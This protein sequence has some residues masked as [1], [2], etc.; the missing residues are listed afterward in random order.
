MSLLWEHPVLIHGRLGRGTV[1]DDE[2]T[3]REDLVVYASARAR[4]NLRRREGAAP[5]EGRAAGHA[6]LGRLTMEYGEPPKLDLYRVDFS[7]LQ[8]LDHH[9][10]EGY[11]RTLPGG[12]RRHL[13]LAG[14]FKWKP[15]LRAATCVGSVFIAAG[16]H[17]DAIRRVCWRPPASCTSTAGRRCRPSSRGERDG[18]RRLLWP[19][20]TAAS[21]NPL[22]P[23]CLTMAAVD[24]A[25]LEQ[26]SS[27]LQ[28]YVYM[29]VDP[30]TGV[31]FYV[32]KG[33]GLRHTAH[34]SEALL[35]VGHLIRRTYVT[36]DRTSR[37][38]S[39]RS[40]RLRVSP[41]ASPP[42]HNLGL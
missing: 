23:G 7:E 28:A 14:N 24:Q 19:A 17:S 34:V 2:G 42:T 12:R 26:L 27:E 29:L 36:G 39:T 21:V 4:S 40:V 9:I 37:A 20:W 32:G 1:V 25:V 18:E 33:H 35:P 13:S 8:A 30:E 15:D 5:L 10:W 38:G 16:R 31:P 6:R 11:C 22:L 41:G 3:E